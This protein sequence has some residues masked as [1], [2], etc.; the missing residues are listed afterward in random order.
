MSLLTWNESY[1]VGVQTL[2]RQ[3]VGL[4]NTLNELHAAMLKGE[5]KNMTGPLLRKLL[6]YTK[7][8]FAAEEALMAS[9]KYPKLAEH[10]AQHRDL[11]RQVNDY[12]SRFER[13]ELTLSV[14]LLNFLRDWLTGHIQKTD[15]DYAPCLNDHGIR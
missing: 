13:G 6:T 4:F 10:I 5:A 14:H 8:H 11:T 15:R 1:S 3:H 2:D 9:A 7:E 12:V